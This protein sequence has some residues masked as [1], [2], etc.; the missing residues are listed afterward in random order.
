[1]PENGDR[2]NPPRDTADKPR[3]GRE[4][5]EEE[6]RSLLAAGPGLSNRASAIAFL[7]L[8]ALLGAGLHYYLGDQGDSSFVARLDADLL[9][10]AE[11]TVSAMED[12]SKMAVVPSW[13][14]RLYASLRRD[15]AWYAAAALV[16]AFLWGL[17]VQARAR[18]SAYLVHEQLSREVAELRRRVAELEKADPAAGRPSE[19]AGVDTKG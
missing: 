7:A 4:Q 13:P 3:P 18:R 1:M 8:L 5:E 12:G 9:S 6:L 10:H 15:I 16:T 17:A 14:Y 2:G 19:P 11:M